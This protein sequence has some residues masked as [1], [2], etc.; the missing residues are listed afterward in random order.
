[1]EQQILDRVADLLDGKEHLQRV[2][3]VVLE[4]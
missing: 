2:A 1:M 4:L 3:M